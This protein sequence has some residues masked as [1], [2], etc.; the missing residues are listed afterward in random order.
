MGSQTSL[1][2]FVSSM[3][4]GDGGQFWNT[5]RR[6]QG[7]A[8]RPC[9]PRRR[10]L[11]GRRGHAA[12]RS[13]QRTAGQH[14]SVNLSFRGYE[15]ES[16]H[17]WPNSIDY[18]AGL[19]DD[20]LYDPMGEPSLD[21]FRM[22][23]PPSMHHGALRP[24]SSS[25]EVDVPV[26]GRC[27]FTP[28]MP[29]LDESSFNDDPNDSYLSANRTLIADDGDPDDPGDPCDD[30]GIHHL[31]FGSC[32]AAD[33]GLNDAELHWYDDGL[34]AVDNDPQL[35]HLVGKRKYEEMCSSPVIPHRSAPRCRSVN[36]AM[37][38]P[39]R[40]EPAAAGSGELESP[41]EELRAAAIDEAERDRFSM[42]DREHANPA[43]RL[44]SGSVSTGA[45]HRTACPGYALG[46]GASS[47]S[48]D[49][50]ATIPPYAGRVRLPEAHQ[51]PQDNSGES[52][53]R[54]SSCGFNGRSAPA[55]CDTQA[56]R[57]H[58]C[59][60]GDPLA[61]AEVHGIDSQLSSLSLQL[62]DSPADASSRNELVESPV[63]LADAPASRGHTH[64][65]YK[66]HPEPL[67]LK[68]EA[69]ASGPVCEAA[70]ATD[71]GVRTQRNASDPAA[72]PV[73]TNQCCAVM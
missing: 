68:A 3:A 17:M 66:T 55:Q 20:F 31:T 44:L 32:L 24:L 12:R 29:H 53:S 30:R 69:G 45:Q 72:T 40:S 41:A 43:A 65:V 19:G 23:Y 6:G 52:W 59:A 70:S 33:E 38:V 28:A 54:P 14:S 60:Q 25:D 27:D 62:Q 34:Q 36:A 51:A 13:V 50:R 57:E 71:G 37:L 42:H 7:G 15:W 56:G 26:G 61:A 21:G 22:N 5:A 10:Q 49:V 39:I 35:G 2:E 11:Q 58:L 1:N 4:Y 16:M 8:A 46:P 63:A 48:S 64:A 47:S 67:A 9:V 73:K 18:H